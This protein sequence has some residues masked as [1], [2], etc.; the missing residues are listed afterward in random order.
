MT[1]MRALKTLP[2]CLTRLVEVL[3]NRRATPPRSPEFHR[4][5]ALSDADLRRMGL[6]RAV[7]P[8]HLRQKRGGREL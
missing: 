1:L 8:R 4:L 6:T 3:R 7:L 5:N 2:L